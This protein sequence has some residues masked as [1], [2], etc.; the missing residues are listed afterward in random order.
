MEK[1]DKGKKDKEKEEER[2]KNT[3]EDLCR[4]KERLEHLGLQRKSILQHLDGERKLFPFVCEYKE[5]LQK[6][7]KEE[8]YIAMQMNKLKEGGVFT[9]SLGKKSTDP[10]VQFI[11]R[12]ER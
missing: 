6:L 3:T 5:I 9:S 11:W 7:D 10:E 2:K 4:L 8:E 12:R 1:K